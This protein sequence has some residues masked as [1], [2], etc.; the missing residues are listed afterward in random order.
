[1]VATIPQGTLFYH[2][3]SED[4]PV[5]GA[6]WL[7]FEPDHAMVFARPKRWKLPKH[8]REGKRP[9]S[10]PPAEPGGLGG[11]GGPPPLKKE[12][13]PGQMAGQM[14]PRGQQVFMATDEGEATAV[15]EQDGNGPSHVG[16]LH[17]YR[18]KRDLTVLYTDGMSAGK[19]RY[20]TTGTQDYLLLNMTQDRSDNPTFGDEL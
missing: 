16:Y 8:P 12:P 2:G 3:T 10:P 4:T 14:G 20:D 5:Q 9:P 15:N 18:T 1:M 11:P 7:A 13:K 6:E 17:T 19:T